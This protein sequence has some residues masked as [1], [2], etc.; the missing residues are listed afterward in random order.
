MLLSKQDDGDD[1]DTRSTAAGK[2][3]GAESNRAAAGR[4]AGDSIGSPAGTLSTAP[5]D[6]SRANAAR[7]QPRAPPTAVRAEAAGLS[8]HR[9]ADSAAPSPCPT[10]RAERGRAFLRS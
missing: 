7:R 2:N 10:A 4:R 9:S 5:L 8:R 6:Q 1:D 3:H